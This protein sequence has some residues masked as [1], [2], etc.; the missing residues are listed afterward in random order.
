[1]IK[2][3]RKLETLE[4]NYTRKI[5]YSKMTKETRKTRNTGEKR[6]IKN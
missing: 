5:K 6:D 1:M 4:K 3:T 2:E